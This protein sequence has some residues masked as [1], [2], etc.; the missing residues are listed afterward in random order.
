MSLHLNDNLITYDQY[1]MYE[2]LNIFGI[3]VEDIPKNRRE[4]IN[5]LVEEELSKSNIQP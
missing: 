5:L 4:D 2:I 1:F 3:S